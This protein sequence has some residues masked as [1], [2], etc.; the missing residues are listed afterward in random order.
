MGGPRNGGGGGRKRKR[1]FE[2]RFR[3]TKR[4][5]SEGLRQRDT[6][7][8][9]DTIIKLKRGI[10]KEEKCDIEKPGMGQFKCII[11][12][13]YFIT[14]GVL[15]IHKKTKKHKKMLKKVSRPQYTQKEADQ[16]GG[17]GREEN[18]KHKVLDRF[19]RESNV[20]L[21]TVDQ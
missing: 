3:R 10:L 7:Q 14:K 17:V 20:Q 19:K 15:A 16:C 13:R 21:I 4:R 18:T 1:T 6:D 2:R 9:Q 11:C 8:I 5:Y 12:A